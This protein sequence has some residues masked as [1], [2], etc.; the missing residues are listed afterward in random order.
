MLA[1]AKHTSYWDC[2]EEFLQQN[3]HLFWKKA[4]GTKCVYINLNA[5]VP[6]VSNFEDGRDATP[7]TAE[8]LRKLALEAVPCVWKHEQ[9][10]D[11]I[12]VECQT[13][14]DHF[15]LHFAQLKCGGL[16][17]EFDGGNLA[18]YADKAVVNRKFSS[19]R[20]YNFH[21]CSGA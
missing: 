4:R 20:W 15:A 18:T 7:L 10:V 19:Q 14:D 3:S 6:T 12:V 21:R 5:E 13:E 1:A 9:G 17:I 16:Y 11:I 2:I 8:I